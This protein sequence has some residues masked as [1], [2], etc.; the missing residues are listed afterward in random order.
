MRNNIL[1][2]VYAVFMALMVGVLVFMMIFHIRK[3]LT[4][5]TDKI[6]LGAYVLM[7]IW[8]VVRVA[9]AIKALLK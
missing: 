1:K 3:G 2:I 6:I 8:G 7:I 4:S 5:T 9:T